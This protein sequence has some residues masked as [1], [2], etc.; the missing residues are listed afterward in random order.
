MKNG[1]IFSQ[2]SQS[3]VSVIPVAIAGK[4]YDI[5][6]GSGLL[7]AA[8]KLISPFCV[9]SGPVAI[10]TDE[11]VW[12]LWGKRLAS[13]LSCAGISFAP[14]IFPAGEASKTLDGLSSL[15]DGF[16]RM[17]LGRDGL[18][19]AFGGGVAGDMAGF[20]AATWMRG[21]RYVQIPTTLLA[22]I[23]SSVGGKTAVNLPHGKNLAGAFHQPKLV[24]IDP[25]TLETLPERE[26]KC[27]MAEAIKYGAIR[28]AALFK[29]LAEKSAGRMEGM[30]EIIGECCRIKGEIT[31]RDEFDSGERMLLNFGHTFGHAIEKMTGFGRHS[32]GEAVAFGM[33]IAADLGERAGFTQPGTGG[34]IRGAL[35]ALG[36]AADCPIDP[37]ELLPLISFDKKGVAGGV[38]M[39]FLRRIGEAFINKMSFTE[40][41]ALLEAPKN[42]VGSCFEGGLG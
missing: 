31:A 4:E 9:S 37:A 42:P 10:V 21:V 26:I 16:A 40:I 18:V 2:A 36:L 20:A 34:E 7:D 38:R 27:G 17:A 3:A 30:G 13:S 32:H 29:G 33:A 15:Y 41:E 12:R 24:L 23:D 19:V 35:A 11:N 8:G 25:A 14:V 22:Q 28:S 1:E 6:I 5:L 39:I